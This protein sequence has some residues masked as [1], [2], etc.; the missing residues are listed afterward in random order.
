MPIRREE[1][2]DACKKGGAAMEEAMRAMD[3]EWSARLVRECRRA[4]R[5]VALA[6]DIVQDAF[7]KAW[8]SCSQFRGESQLFGWLVTIVRRCIVDYWRRVSPGESLDG[9]DGEP[10]QE[11]E[12]RMAELSIEAGA[13]PE[14]DLRRKQVAECLKREG[15]RFFESSPLHAMVMRWVA[16]DG[17]TNDEVGR[18]LGR[19]SGATRE[20]ISQARKKARVAYARCYELAFG[21]PAEAGKAGKVGK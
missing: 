2:I 4:V 3:R 6:E 9:P 17:L 10:S 5:D 18:L 1:F 12:A 14:I 13:T 8:K 19:N 20:F 21:S 7:I 16:E 15:R 11:V